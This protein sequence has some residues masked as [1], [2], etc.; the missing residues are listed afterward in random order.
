MHI[1]GTNHP[2]ASRGMDNDRKYAPHPGARME[3]E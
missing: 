3:K 2:G 1:K